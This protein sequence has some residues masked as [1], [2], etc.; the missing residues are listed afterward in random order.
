MSRPRIS[1]LMPTHCRPDVVG[2]A[3]E[4]VLNQTFGDFELLVVGDGAIP[5]T[6]QAV[7]RFD[8]PRIRYF[9][10]PKAPHFGYANRNV[11]LRESRGE[12]IGF[13]ADDDLLFPDH[14]ETL[15]RGLESGAAITYS[16]A[17]WVSTDGIVAPFLTNLEFQDEMD[18][19][20]RGNTIAAS[21]FLYRA[22]ALPNRD[23]WPEDVPSAADWRLWNRILDANPQSRIVYCRTP[24]VLHFSARRKASRHSA[25]PQL[26]E[27][28]AIADSAAWWPSALR[29]P[30][31]PGRTEQETFADLMRGTPGWC[32][33]IRQASA[34]LAARLA[35]DEIQHNRAT[36]N[37]RLQAQAGQLAAKDAPPAVR[38]VRTPVQR[39]AAEIRRIP[40]NI[41]RLFRG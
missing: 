29:V 23:A 40:R 24:T 36:T 17:L 33:H 7:K 13:A 12:L 39:I 3:V 4:S 15:L 30:I 2:L 27:F 25:M 21:C 8:D 1:I 22:D 34:D 18:A 10:L 14:L 28:I 16:Q 37:R 41:I 32:S 26:A 31:G 38:S 9:D 35:W 6:A 11:A 5:G 19:F 20:R